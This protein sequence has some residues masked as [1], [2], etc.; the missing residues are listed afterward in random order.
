MTTAVAIHARTALERLRLI[1]ELV[2][3][4]GAEVVCFLRAV[5]VLAGDE[6]VLVN[7][8]V[9]VLR[10]SNAGSAVSAWLNPSPPS[11]V[12]MA[13]RNS[14][15]DWKRWSRFLASARVT[16]ATTS[17]GSSGLSSLTEGRSLWMMFWMTPM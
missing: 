8:R 7:R 14:R 17:G 4:H 16:S 13:L 2:V 11:R 15:A 3:I 10:S 9:S 1:A 12:S 5:D 6:V